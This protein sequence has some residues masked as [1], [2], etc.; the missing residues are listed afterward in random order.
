MG[1]AICCQF[2]WIDSPFYIGIG[3]VCIGLGWVFSVA[4][5]VIGFL[6]HAD[7]NEYGGMGDECKGMVLS[8]SVLQT[9]EA[10][11]VLVVLC[12]ACFEWLS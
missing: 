1:F 9:I 7:M 10:L 4:W 5:M 6:L 2:D 8:W 12:A 3:P 11:P